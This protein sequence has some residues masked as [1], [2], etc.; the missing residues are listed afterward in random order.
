MK[1]INILIYRILA[2]KWS[3]V[4]QEASGENVVINTTKIK[5]VKYHLIRNILKITIFILILT[6]VLGT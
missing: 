3:E 5:K 4:I 1:L 6:L 2:E